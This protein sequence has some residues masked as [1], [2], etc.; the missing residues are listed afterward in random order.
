MHFVWRPLEVDAGDKPGPDEESKATDAEVRNRQDAASFLQ[1]AAIAVDEV[2][3]KSLRRRAAE[4][5]FRRRTGR[6]WS[7]RCPRDR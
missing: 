6:R 4:L 3:R 7:S 5:L 1:A 2:A